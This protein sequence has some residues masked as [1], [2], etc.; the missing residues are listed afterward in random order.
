MRKLTVAAFMSLD[1]VIQAPGGP[2][3]DTSGQFRFG[4][5]IVPYVD[6]AI[7]Q[8]IQDLFSQPFELLLGRHT[9]DIFAGYW[10]HVQADSKSHFIADLFNSVPKHVAT[11]RPDT[12]DWQNSHALKGNLADAIRALKNQDGAHLLTQGSGDLVHQ[13]LAA[14]LVDELRLM[15]YPIMLGHGKRLFDDNAQASAFT[16][17]RSMSTPGGVLIARY[18]RSGDVRTGTFDDAE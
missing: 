10:P 8:A 18:E 4:G 1:G 17:A 13:L 6:E 11:H 5:W 3:E 9:Y 14:G 16:L 2:E 12:L 15:I 7:G